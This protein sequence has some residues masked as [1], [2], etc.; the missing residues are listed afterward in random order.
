MRIVITTAFI[1]KLAE[2]PK[3]AEVPAGKK[4]NVTAERGQELIDLGLAEAS[5]T[6]AAKGTKSGSEPAPYNAAPLGGAPI[7]PGDAG[8][9]DGHPAGEDTTHD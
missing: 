1:D 8:P 7:D 2:D 9:I 6:D 3:D 4:M 5:D